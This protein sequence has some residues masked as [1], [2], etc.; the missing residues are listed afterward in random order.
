MNCRTLLAST[1][2]VAFLGT[3]SAQSATNV[4]TY[5]KKFYGCVNANTKYYYCGDGV[6]YNTVGTNSS[7]LTLNSNLTCSNNFTRDYDN[8]IYPSTYSFNHNTDILDIVELPLGGAS[9]YLNIKNGESLRMKVRSVTDK[10]SYIELVYHSLAATGTDN[11]V[12]ENNTMVQFLVFNDRLKAVKK[13]DVTKVDKVLLPQSAD[14]FTVYMV[15][16]GA[17]FNITVLASSSVVSRALAMFAAV[18]SIFVL[19]F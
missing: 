3:V 10:S 2:L 9:P 6:C 4:T 14:T 5:Y 13:F 17:D 16:R 1:V 8:P 18:L 7:T 15:A 11:V 19:A 12:K